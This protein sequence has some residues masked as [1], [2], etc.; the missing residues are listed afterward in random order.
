MVC[1]VQ[2]DVLPKWFFFFFFF[3][4]EAYWKSPSVVGLNGDSP[5]G[6]FISLF[7]EPVIVTYLE[8]L[9][10]GILELRIWR[11]GDHSELSGRVRWTKS[12]DKCLYKKRNLRQITEADWMGDTATSQGTATATISWK[13]HRTDSP[14][15]PPQGVWPCWHP[16]F[17]FLASRTENTFLL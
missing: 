2:Y 1:F 10:A 6:V 13:W 7:L 15:E 4:F 11:E 8:K 9:F 17:G 16:Y 5:K 3:T 12:N 14:L